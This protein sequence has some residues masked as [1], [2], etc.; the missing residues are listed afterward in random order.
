MEAVGTWQRIC[1]GKRVGKMQMTASMTGAFRMP[2]F[3]G[4]ALGS[5]FT[6]F[7]PARLAPW[8]R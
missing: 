5:L 7:L 2:L 1:S 4:G 3:G 8:V 6:G